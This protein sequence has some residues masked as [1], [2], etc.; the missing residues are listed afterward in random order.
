MLQ[1][2]AI[3]V[4]ALFVFFCSASARAEETELS[5]LPLEI[6]GFASQ[7]FLFSSHQNNYLAKSSRGSFEYTEVGLNFTKPLS[8]RLRL[9]L[10]IFAND[11]GPTGNYAITADWFF[12]DYK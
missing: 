10:Q 7:G 1:R 12:L 9:G 3:S 2:S 5:D 4:V 6:H 8:D 11:L